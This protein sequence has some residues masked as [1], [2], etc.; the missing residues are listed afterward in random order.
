MPAWV[1]DNVARIAEAPPELWPHS[2]ARR[3]G[4]KDDRTLRRSP[5]I[6]LKLQARICV[7]GDIRYYPLCRNL[8]VR[9]RT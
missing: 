9:F 8:R 3:I 7:A 6:D 5:A 4:F 2:V 1:F